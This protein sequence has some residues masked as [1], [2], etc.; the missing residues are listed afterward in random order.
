LFGV[1]SGDYDF[2][3]MPAKV[4][5][6]RLNALKEEQERIGKSINKKVMVRSAML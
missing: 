4:A 2:D 1:A 6:T 3:A 5:S